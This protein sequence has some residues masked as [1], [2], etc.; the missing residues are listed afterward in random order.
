[1]YSKVISFVLFTVLLAIIVY[2]ILYMYSNTHEIQ[3]PTT[4]NK[5]RW[6]C[7]DDMK[8]PKLDQKGTNCYNN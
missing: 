3:G 1:M 4:C 7:C 5:T 2:F 8:T 6:G